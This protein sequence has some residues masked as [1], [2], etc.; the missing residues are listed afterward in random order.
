MNQWYSYMYILRGF[1]K[2][3]DEPCRPSPTHS[4]VFFLF[5]WIIPNLIDTKCKIEVLRMLFVEHPKLVNCEWKQGKMANPFSLTLWPGR[6]GQAC[7]IMELFANVV[8]RT[9]E[10]PVHLHWREMHRLGICCRTKC[11]PST[12]SNLASCAKAG[13]SPEVTGPVSGPSKFEDENF[14]KKHT[15]PVVLPM[16]NAGPGTNGS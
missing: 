7:V 3:I 12:G 16:A 11:L 15:G 5:F 9:A 8:L 14:K 10:N 6:R 1:V 4:H 2:V 13:I